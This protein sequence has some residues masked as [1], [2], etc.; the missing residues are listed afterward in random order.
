[1]PKADRQ[2]K[3]VPNGRTVEA[4]SRRS[5]LATA[6]AL[7]AVGLN[8][9]SARAADKLTVRLDW[10]THGMH[11]PFFLSIEKGW[12]KSA[13]LEVSFEDGNGSVTTSQL[14]GSGQFDIGHAALAPMA[15]GVSKGLA[16]TSIAGFIRRGDTG[17]LVPKEKRWTRPSDLVGKRIVYTAGS[18]EG[19]FIRPFFERNGVP[20]DKITLLNVEASAKLSTYFTGD[21]D[22]AAST[23]PWPIPIAEGKRDSGGIL[24]ADFGFDLP[25][26]GLVV[27]VDNLKKKGPALRRFASLI[28]GAWGYILNGH[29]DEGTSAILAHRPQAPLSAKV[30]RSQIETY[31]PFFHTT[32]TKVTPVGLQS[33][34]DWQMTIDEMQK[35]DVMPKGVKPQQIFTND[36]VDLNFAKTVIGS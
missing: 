33:E 32:A 11:A 31:R 25:G 1:M 30:L 34:I 36:F 3:R 15:I 17:I 9:R 18:L 23:V 22:A 7:F 21:C 19:P 10:S 4:V 28:S 14:V 26:Y 20:L 27:Q 8:M 29:E 12:F 13:D 24:F 6:A 35:A 2:Q 5:A 16:V